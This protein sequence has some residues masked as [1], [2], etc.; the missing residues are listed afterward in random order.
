MRGE[1]SIIRSH[2]L[3]PSLTRA[4]EGRRRNRSRSD[5]GAGQGQKIRSRAIVCLCPLPTWAGMPHA[6][7]DSRP[8]VLLVEDEPLV[9]MYN[10]D[11]LDEAGFR[12]LEASNAEEAVLL[13]DARPDICALVTDIEMPGRMNGLTL[14][15]H[16]REKQASIGLLVVSGRV[17]PGASE[18][19]SGSRFLGK[20]Y[21]PA[22][23][24]REL[25]ASIHDSSQQPS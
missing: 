17:R 7:N 23:L 25:H 2:W 18:L 14:A 3:L 15:R 11:V 10:A 22:D 6:P 4:R 20:P 19:P 21:T 5:W 1:I 8:V 12:I 13:F 9:R 16:I 24:L